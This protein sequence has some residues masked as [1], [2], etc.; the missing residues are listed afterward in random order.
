MSKQKINY[1]DTTP[2]A[3]VSSTTGITNVPCKWQ[4]DAPNPDPTVDRNA[5][6]YVPV[7]EVPA[8]GV[9]GQVLTKSSST[10]HDTAWV[11]PPFNTHSESLTDGAGNFIFAGGDIVTVVG[12]PD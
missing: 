8:G 11:T 12:V 9:A 4:A 6:A 10:D 5:S 7:A 2:A 1:N 3:P